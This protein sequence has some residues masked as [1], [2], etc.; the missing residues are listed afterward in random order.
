MTAYDD[1]DEP[2]DDDE[3][4]Y[5]DDGG[6]DDPTM[7]CPYCGADVYDDAVRCPACEQYLSD[8]ERT[9]VNQRPWV[10]VTA[11]FLLA[12]TLWAYLGRR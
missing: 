8:E 1:E 3:S 11:V 4:P 5:E 6:D 7:P 10:V 12:L 9:S 2:D